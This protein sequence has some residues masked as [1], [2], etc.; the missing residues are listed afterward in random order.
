MADPT[1]RKQI[2]TY[3]WS[4]EV[5]VWNVI[6]YL[7]SPT[8]YREFLPSRARRNFLQQAEPRIGDDGR[9]NN[10]VLFPKELESQ[11]KLRKTQESDLVLLDEIRGRWWPR[12]R[13]ITLLA[14]IFCVLLLVMVRS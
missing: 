12:L 10:R 2:E 5:R 6:R 9:N 13:L 7:D 11:R 4:T 8:N 3:G 14:F 1:Q